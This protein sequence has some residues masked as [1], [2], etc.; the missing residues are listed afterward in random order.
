MDYRTL[1]PSLLPKGLIVYPTPLGV[2]SVTALMIGQEDPRADLVVI[3]YPGEHRTAEVVA[4]LR[5]LQQEY[6]LDLEDPCVVTLV[7]GRHIDIMS[8][9]RR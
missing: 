3:T 1:V 6:L 9:Q 8:R 2:Y 7:M 4:T 5:R